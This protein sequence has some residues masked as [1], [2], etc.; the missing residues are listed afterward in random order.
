MSEVMQARIRW[1]SPE[2]GG[3]PAPPVG[4]RY[5]TVARFE[6]QRAE[7]EKEAWSLVVEWQ[8]PIDAAGWVTANVRFLVPENAPS[9][10]LAVGSRFELMEGRRVVA[11]GEV[12]E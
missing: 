2:E 4:P 1:L 8:E 10:L 7:W 9:Q 5:S 11:Q 6:K 3:R 12:V